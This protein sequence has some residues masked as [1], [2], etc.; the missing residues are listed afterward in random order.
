M[1]A[2]NLGT[3]CSFFSITQFCPF[4]FL[5]IPLP[6]PLPISITL[7]QTTIFHPDYDKRYLTTLPSSSP[8][9]I[10]S[11]LPETIRLILKHVD[12]LKTFN[13]LS[14]R[15]VITTPAPWHCTSLQDLAHAYLSSPLLITLDHNLLSGNTK[16]LLYANMFLICGSLTHL[17]CIWNVL[18]LLILQC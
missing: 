7:V 17:S 15:M 11:I 13:G 18:P 5:N 9:P 8:Q 4:N 1:K 12:L 14:S 10:K 6:L 3:F 16:M 2:R